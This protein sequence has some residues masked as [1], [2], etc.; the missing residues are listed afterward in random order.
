MAD[1]CHKL[2]L[3]VGLSLALT[4]GGA[5]A[6]VIDRL[7]AVVNDELITAGDVAADNNLGVNLLAEVLPSTGPA[8]DGDPSFDEQ[9]Q[10]LIDR[11]ILLQEAHA[12]GVGVSEQEAASAVE[13]LIDQGRLPPETGR[14]TALNNRVRDELTVL[15]LIN[16]EVRSNLVVS[17]EE[18]EAYYRT[19]PERFT[20]PA[21]FRIS[22]IVFRAPDGTD[23]DTL[24]RKRQEAETLRDEL[25]HGADFAAL[26]KR[27][28]DGP[29]AAKG[30]D[31][32][33]FRP[34]EL[35]PA[36]DR[37]VASMEEG[38]VSPV[39]TTPIGFHLIKLTEKR[40]GRV[41]PLEDVR[42]EVED[43]VYQEQ[44]AERYRRWLRQLRHRAHIEVK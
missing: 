21:Q 17:S 28:S 15:K 34:G 32:G 36:I 13:S 20:S 6:A 8:S 37:A 16:R 30:G 1:R 10:R 25:A 29:E 40:A 41:K 2:Y 5:I 26:A 11:R 31:L 18:I 23:A 24:G 44:T 3:A 42:N 27:H 39:L 38:A 4:S 43:Q 14:T 12:M 19:H 9:L 35:L 22:Q 33:V 7:V